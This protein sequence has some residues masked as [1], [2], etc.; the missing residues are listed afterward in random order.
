MRK[1]MACAAVAAFL[2]FPAIA[3]AHPW[4]RDHARCGAGYVMRSRRTRR[5]VHGRRVVVWHH[6]CVRRSKAAKAAKAAEH[7][8]GSPQTLL[9]VKVPAGS[10]PNPRPPIT[11]IGD[12]PGCS[13]SSADPAIWLSQQGGRVVRVFVNP[14]IGDGAL[15]CAQA[16]VRDG[17]Q[18]ALSIQWWNDW[19]VQQVQDFFGQMLAI[20]GPYAWS[21]SV[22]N[23]QE[24]QEG[25]D[26]APGISGDQYAA[27]WQAVE[28]LLLRFAPQAI[29]VAGEISPWGLPF[30]QQAVV[31][32][33]PGVQ[34]LAAHPYPYSGQYAFDIPTWVN[35]TH[36]LGLQ[37]WFT[38][39]LCGPHDW[40]QGDCWSVQQSQA[41]GADVALE[42]W[43]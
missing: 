43:G 31:D 9:P 26:G 15:G 20:Y 7:A 12:I 35:W 3:Q 23:E 6:K 8:P 40:Y 13:D 1:A 5:R 21:V 22:G 10:I 25:P 16:A 11:G 33:L 17:A 18:V 41:M 29:K 19:T 27:V 30:L 39:S 38:E 4:K 2:S 28:P 24:L 34:A 42:W 32:G 37:A 14:W 36:R